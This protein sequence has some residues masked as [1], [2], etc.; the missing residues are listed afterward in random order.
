G[1]L[2]RYAVG[3]L[4]HATFHNPVHHPDILRKAAAGGLET[5][6]DAHFLIDGALRVKLMLAIKT[7]LARNVMEGHHAVPRAKLLDLGPHA[8]HHARRLMAENAWRHQQVVLDLLQVRMADAA[9]LH[10]NQDFAWPDFGRGNFLDLHQALSA[11]HGGM[12]SGGYGVHFRTGNLQ[13]NPPMPVQPA[14]N[15]SAA[16]EAPAAGTAGDRK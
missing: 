1:A 15:G 10:P 13:K 8:G 12:H 6:R 14:K 7:I 4:L 11:V 16:E 9:G 5:G 2:E 3:N